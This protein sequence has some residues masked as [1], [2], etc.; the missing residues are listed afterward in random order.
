MPLLAIAIALAQA[1]A[2]ADCDK[3]LLFN[4]EEART[5]IS[6]F[7]E[8][9]AQL[10]KQLLD[11]DSQRLFDATKADNNA[12]DFRPKPNCQN[13]ARMYYYLANLLQG[14]N[15]YAVYGMRFTD[16]PL[17]RLEQY[18]GHGELTVELFK[19]VIRAEMN[20]YARQK[21]SAPPVTQA[22]ADKYLPGQFPAQSPK[23]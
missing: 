17:W 11:E 8:P 16:P 23:P 12:E 10:K 22:L 13:D 21:K 6:I 5:Q 18:V 7:H 15:S 1:P 20:I 4:K 14:L 9:N 19:Q 3:A 2:R